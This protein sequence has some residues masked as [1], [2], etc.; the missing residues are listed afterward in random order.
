MVDSAPDISWGYCETMLSVRT[1][2]ST[3]GKMFTCL[4]GTQLYQS[5]DIVGFDFETLD[6]TV[7]TEPA[8]AAAARPP[9]GPDAPGP[10]IMITSFRTSDVN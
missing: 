10:E 9:V 4:I 2:N 8:A 1:R 3:L 5:Q 7:I 6:C